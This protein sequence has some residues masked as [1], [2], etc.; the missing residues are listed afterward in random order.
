M[1]QGL[2]TG[3]GLHVCMWAGTSPA[4]PNMQQGAQPCASAMGGVLSLGRI[5]VGVVHCPLGDAHE[6]CRLRTAH[7]LG[8]G[9]PWVGTF[10]RTVN[11]II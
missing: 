2:Q 3:Q 7:I 8:M 1:G 10:V 5:G 11:D 6:Q 9:G 4:L